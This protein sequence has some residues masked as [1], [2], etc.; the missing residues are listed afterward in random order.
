MAH[1]ARAND[2]L[3]NRYGNNLRF[4]FEDCSTEK[5]KEKHER[6]TRKQEASS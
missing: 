1:R 5:L 2:G 3:R 6:G 4:I